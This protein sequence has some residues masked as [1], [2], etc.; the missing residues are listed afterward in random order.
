MPEVKR[1]ISREERRHRLLAGAGELFGAHG[2]RGTEVDHIARRAG[3]TKPMIYRHFPG[4]KAEIFLAV[5]DG[6]MDS[7]MRALWEA[8]ASSTEPRERLRHGLEAYLRFAEENPAGFRLLARASAELDPGLGGQLRQMRETIAAG[9]SNTIADVMRGAGLSAE[10][11]PLYAQALL[12]GVESV[13]IW[14]LEHGR[15]QELQEIVD[16]LLAFLWRGFDGLPRDPTR[17]QT[18]RQA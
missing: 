1:R 6:Y 16:H 14:W 10:G 9:L 7:L 17:F 15:V 12:G 3:V 13:T 18:S 11:A 4:G 2:Y 8:L 5:L